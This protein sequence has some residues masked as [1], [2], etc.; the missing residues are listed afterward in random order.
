MNSTNFET[1]LFRCSSIGKI[2]T[3]PRSGNGL[4]KTCT[5]HLIEVYVLEKYGRDKDITTKYMEK[6]LAVEE[7]SITLYSR[8]KKRFYKKNEIHLKNEFIKGM[9]DIFEGESIY[10]A[11]VVPDIKSSWDLNTFF[12]VL[13]D[14]VNSN[15]Q[16]QLQGY[17]ALTNAKVVRLAY[18]LVNTPEKIINDEL[19][20]LQWK[21][22]VID[23]TGNELFQQ[24]EE[25][26]RANMTFDD[27]P[28]DERLIEFEFD[29]DQ[30]FIDEMYHRVTKCREW[31]CDFDVKMRNRNIGSKTLEASSIL[32]KIN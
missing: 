18:C 5:S 24:A 1:T 26:L 15:Y 31:L 11:D 20:K 7:D 13:A 8:I 22:G 6:G 23:P 16:A 3:N 17:S 10:N 30:D 14:D 25:Q 12:A 21:M 2:M 19:R 27:I 32:K 29:R 9:P 28:M 4:S